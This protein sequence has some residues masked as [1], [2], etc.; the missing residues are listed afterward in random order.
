[1]RQQAQRRY[2]DVVG[3]LGAKRE[4]LQQQIEALEQ[5]DREYRNRL[6]GFMQKQMRALWADQPDAPDE[7]EIPAGAQVVTGE[8]IP[9]Q[10]AGRTTMTPHENADA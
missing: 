1:M 6:L 5:F 10:R 4:A 8:L 9:V 3:S 2:D 7:V